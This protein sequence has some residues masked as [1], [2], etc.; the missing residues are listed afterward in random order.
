MKDKQSVLPH[1][2]NAIKQ[3]VFGKPVT[4]SPLVSG[5]HREHQTEAFSASG[6][7]EYRVLHL[8]NDLANDDKIYPDTFSNGRMTEVIEWTTLSNGTPADG[9]R[10]GEW[11]QSLFNRGGPT[12]I[13]GVVDETDGDGQTGR[14]EGV[15]GEVL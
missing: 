12:A 4:S 8:I 1:H 6:D 10:Q 15:G 14:R 3:K 2:F 9:G 11:R 5:G 7:V 13:E